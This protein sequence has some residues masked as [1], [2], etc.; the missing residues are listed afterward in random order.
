MHFL[1]KVSLAVDA[2]VPLI[3]AIEVRED[4]NFF[5]QLKIP[6]LLIMLNI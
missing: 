3:L 1:K 4:W 2:K 6:N 5:P